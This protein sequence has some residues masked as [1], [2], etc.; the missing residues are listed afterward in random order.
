ME[1]C[2]QCRWWHNEICCNVA[3]DEIKEGCDYFYD[4][5]DKNNVRIE[6]ET[7]QG[8]DL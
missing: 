3:V 2:K 1:K 7:N 6:D 4:Y 5:I 8:L